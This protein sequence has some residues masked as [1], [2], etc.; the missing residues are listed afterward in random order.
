MDKRITNNY[1]NIPSDH[2]ADYYR[3]RASIY[4]KLMH[5]NGWTLY[6]SKLFKL[7]KHKQIRRRLAQILRDQR[8][9]RKI[10]KGI[11]EHV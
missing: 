3:N 9:A 8:T 5:G 11:Y 7:D 2:I 10:V 1:I 6:K 4:S